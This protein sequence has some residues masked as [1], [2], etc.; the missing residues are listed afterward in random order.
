MTVNNNKCLSPLQ[1]KQSDI[2]EL[3]FI[4]YDVFVIPHLYTPSLF[5]LWK[6]IGMQLFCM[7]PRYDFTTWSIS[8]LL[9]NFKP[10]TK[11]T[12]IITS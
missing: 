4:H 3:N 7:A 9:Y 5:P 1:Y 12:R 11:W 2:A 8:M 10:C 6:Y